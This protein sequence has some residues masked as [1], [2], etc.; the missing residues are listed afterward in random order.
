MHLRFLKGWMTS[1][2]LCLVMGLLS[3]AAMAQTKSLV[4]LTLEDSETTDE[5]RAGIRDVLKA[6]GLQEGR[7]YKVQNANAQGSPEMAAKQALE[8]I[9][10]K[11]DVILALSQPSAQ[12]AAGHTTTMPII[13]VGVTDPV[14]AGLVPGWGASG[15]NITGVSD[16]LTLSRRVTLVRQIVPGAR[17]VGVIYN[18]TDASSVAQVREFQTLLG[19]AGLVMV[20]A[21]VTRSVD[22]ASAARS[23]VGR[24]DLIYTLQD[25]T[26]LKSYAQLVAT[27][28]QTRLPL[29]AS[30][31]AHVRL[32]AVAALDIT[33]R[34]VGLAAG[35]LTLRILRGVKPGTIPTEVM[36]KPPL[37]LNAEGA[38]RQGVVLSDALLKSASQ[39]L[40]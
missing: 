27:A 36:Q 28:N 18:P 13:F 34:D 1:V 24:V 16:A 20:E 14:E 30:D 11:P 38:Q 15:T 8:L 40:K 39:V 33:G 6:A 22:V 9:R 5:M 12:A 32:G 4:I 10:G 25:A 21:T 19:E 7:Q 26:V 29:L 31:V 35:R 17:R 2:L 23:M 37:H 3:V